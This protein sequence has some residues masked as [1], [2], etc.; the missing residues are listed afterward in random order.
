MITIEALPVLKP[1]KSRLYI[2]QILMLFKQPFAIGRIL[3]LTDFH[4]FYFRLHLLNNLILILKGLFYN[5]VPLI[6]LSLTEHESTKFLELSFKII[7]ILLFLVI[8]HKGILHRRYYMNSK[9]KQEWSYINP[10]VIN[11]LQ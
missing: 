3:V 2:L 9:L 8:G 11:K 7:S 4:Q 10:R 6:L 1:P 5:F